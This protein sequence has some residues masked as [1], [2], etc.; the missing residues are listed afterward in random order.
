MAEGLKAS[1]HKICYIA[2]N[3]L[4]TRDFAALRAATDAL[5][6]LKALDRVDGGARYFESCCLRLQGKFD[7]ACNLLEEVVETNPAYR[8]R[9]LQSLGWIYFERGHGDAALPLYAAAARIPGDHQLLVI[10]QSQKMTAVV[11]AREGD[12]I[13]ALRELQRLSPLIQAVSRYYPFTYYDYLNSLAVE[14]GEVGRIEEA[15]TVSS[16][17]LASPYA[18]AYPEWTETKR[19]LDPKVPDGRACLVPV[20]RAVDDNPTPIKHARKQDP[21]RISVHWRALRCFVVSQR[22]TAL[23]SYG[24]ARRR[25]PP[26]LTSLVLSRVFNSIAAR[27]PPNPLATPLNAYR[28]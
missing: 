16:I 14:L 3:A 19:E 10:A 15:K 2:T 1:R 23:C 6:E 20:A 8:P 26:R 12:H 21:A 9:A 28:R 5:I 13:A 24:H 17:A 7:Q 27:G 4:L 18:F 22:T 25:D 11:R